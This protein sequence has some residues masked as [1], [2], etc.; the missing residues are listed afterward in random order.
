VKSEI[1]KL[2]NSA[3]HLLKDLGAK[4][5]TPDEQRQYI[6]S[7]SEKFQTIVR[8]ALSANYV[9]DDCFDKQKNLRFATAVVNRNE[10]LAKTLD[11][12]GHAYDFVKAQ[13]ATQIP[14]LSRKISWEFQAEDEDEVMESPKKVS[15]KEKTTRVRFHG[16]PDGLDELP[17]VEKT[18]LNQPQEGISKWLTSVYLTSRGFELGTFDGALLA[19]TMK[20]QSAKW[21]TIAMSYIKDIISMA[22]MFIQDLL[23]VV[24]PDHRVREAL[25]SVLLD[26]LLAKYKAAL[27]FVGFLLQVERT[28]AT[29]NHYFADNLHK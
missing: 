18:I 22:H 27:D 5:E 29:L 21:E 12:H 6:L 9:S 19:M 25:M 10:I 17:V 16:D 13:P 15:E 4:R 28:P 7:I 14:N 11:E 3:K 23:R 26:E 2:L 1:Q 20:T 8:A 24:C